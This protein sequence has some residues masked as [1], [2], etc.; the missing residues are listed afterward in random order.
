MY[1]YDYK[2]Y[3]SKWNYYF[4]CI[5]FILVSGLS[6]RLGCDTIRYQHW[7]ETDFNTPFDLNL[8]FNSSNVGGSAQEPLWLISNWIFYNL[9]GKW[10]IFKTVIAA[11]VNI[12]I[13]SFIKKYTQVPYTAIMLYALLYYF[14]INFQVL[15]E[16]VAIS[17]FLIGLKYII[18]DNKV[19]WK[20][21]FFIILASLFHRFAFIG[22]F[23]PLLI[24]LKYDGRLLL[25]I[26]VISIII[27]YVAILLN[28]IVDLGLLNSLLGERVQ[29]LVSS[30]TYGSNSRNIFGIIE[31]LIL[32]VLPSL[33]LLKNNNDSPF[34]SLALV[35]VIIMI[36]RMT[37][38]TI[39]YRI[40]NYLFF[41]F[42]IALSSSI[43]NSIYRLNYKRQSF[44]ICKSYLMSFICI[45]MFVGS[46]V[47]DI[48]TS[49]DYIM[50]Y[51]YSS[52]ITKE[53]VLQRE[54]YYQDMYIFW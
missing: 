50:Y 51:P 36:F 19:L 41:P 48:I 33:L 13:F 18:S 54:I 39:I 14:E 32:L 17:L 38:L 52:V 26:I 21:Y 28:S 5:L 22:V 31:M 37:S 16:S 11:F 15:R 2:Q 27:P 6:Y 47:K 24:N 29:D 12:T 3:N 4:L 40:N 35:F 42:A 53:E 1:I 49:Q 43:N 25:I 44:A 23:Y 34:L 20:Y 45:L 30:K 9:F 46:S 10:W 7:F 8:F